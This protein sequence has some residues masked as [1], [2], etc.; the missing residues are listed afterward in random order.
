MPQKKK[1]KKQPIRVEK[2]SQTRLTLKSIKKEDPNMP[3]YVTTKTQTE[4][5]GKLGLQKDVSQGTDMLTHI[6][7]K[8]S[9]Y[10]S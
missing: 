10:I 2:S 9:E 4:P 1:G 7:F 3:K 5:L 8:P 6:K